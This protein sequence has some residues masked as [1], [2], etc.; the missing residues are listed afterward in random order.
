MLSAQGGETLGVWAGLVRLVGLLQ[1]GAA[2]PN[3][4]LDIR[5]YASCCQML[6]QLRV[7]AVQLAQEVSDE[8]IINVGCYP[9]RHL[10]GLQHLLQG[11]TQLRHVFWQAQQ[12]RVY[13]CK[14][15]YP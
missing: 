7:E 6:V 9:V 12:H 15:G 5:P 14:F 11:S 10:E 8:I 13:A 2:S 1:L 3:F 4:G